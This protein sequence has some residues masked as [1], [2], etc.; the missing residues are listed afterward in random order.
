MLLL[1]GYFGGTWVEPYAHQDA[2]MGSENNR[3]L[4]RDADLLKMSGYDLSQVDSNA[5]VKL[6]LQFLPWLAG[7]AAGVA[8]LNIGLSQSQRATAEVLLL[9]GVLAIFPLLHFYY[10][11][12][13]A[14]GALGRYSELFR[15]IRGNI[16]ALIDGRVPVNPATL[17]LKSGFIMAVIGTGLILTGALLKSFWYRQRDQ[18]MERRAA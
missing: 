18:E 10:E 17:E 16:N 2:I 15:V 9:C 12:R 13:S 3:A 5:P 1:A 8:L 7:I 6:S 14:V 11:T 4:L